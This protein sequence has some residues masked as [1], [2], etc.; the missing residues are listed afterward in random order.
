VTHV[1]LW[2]NHQVPTIAKP[3]FNARSHRCAGASASPGVGTFVLRFRASGRGAHVGSAI[4][5]QMVCAQ[6]R[7]LHEWLGLVHQVTFGLTIDMVGAVYAHIRNGDPL[8]D[9]TGAIA[10]L[11]AVSAG[12]RGELGTNDLL[13][14]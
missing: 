4:S 7:R 11:L 2:R 8:N 14:R 9:S 3:H 12:I 13:Q 5:D 10:A 6:S 1:E